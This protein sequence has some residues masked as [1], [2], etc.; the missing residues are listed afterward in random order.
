MATILNFYHL[1]AFIVS[2]SPSPFGSGNLYP[3]P[4]TLRAPPNLPPALLSCL[5]SLLSRFDGK[6]TSR[7][8][9]RRGFCTRGGGKFC[10]IVWCVFVYMCMCVC[11]AHVCFILSLGVRVNKDRRLGARGTP[12]PPLQSFSLAPLHPVIPDG[13]WRKGRGCSVVKFLVP[14]HLSLGACCILPVF[15]CKPLSFHLALGP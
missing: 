4:P 1:L 8:E 14:F 9:N 3:T 7:W 6:R 15:G 13:A 5:C 10:A 11:P 2:W 12:S